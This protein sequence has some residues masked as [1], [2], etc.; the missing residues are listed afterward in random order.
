MKETEKYTLRIWI[1][2]FSE[3]SKGYL[4]PYISNN[5]HYVSL[6]SKNHIDIFVN[7]EKVGEVFK[8]DTKIEELLKGKNDKDFNLK[9]TSFYIFQHRSDKA[10]K[11]IKDILNKLLAESGLENDKYA[12]KVVS[13][14]NKDTSI[15]YGTMYEAVELYKEPQK[16]GKTLAYKLKESTDISQKDDLKS[17]SPAEPETTANWED[18]FTCIKDIEI[19]CEYNYYAFVKAL[20]NH[21]LILLNDSFS[22]FKKHLMVHSEKEFDHAVYNQ[23]KNCSK[24][25]ENPTLNIIFA[26]FD[27]T[28]N[29]F[30]KNLFKEIIL[31]KVIDIDDSDSVIPKEE[32]ENIPLLLI[33]KRMDDTQNFYRSSIWTRSVALDDFKNG[34]KYQIKDRINEATEYLTSKETRGFEFTNEKDSLAT[35]SLYSLS[36]AKEFFEFQTRLQ[37]NAYLTGSHNDI[38]PIILHNE[39][40]FKSEFEKKAEEIKTILNK[41]GFGDGNK[42]KFKALLIDDFADKSLRKNKEKASTINKYQILKSLSEGFKTINFKIEKHCS[43]FDLDDVKC[44]IN[45]H[46]PDII[47]LDYSFGQG[48]KKGSEIFKDLAYLIEKDN[49]K[50]REDRELRHRGPFDKLWVFPITAF[51]N[52]FIDEIRTKGLGFIDERYNLSRGADFINTPYLFKYYFAKMV[53]EI[54]QKATETKAKIDEIINDIEKV[55]KWEDL[56]NKQEKASKLFSEHFIKRKNVTF[57]LEAKCYEGI[58]YSIKGNEKTQNNFKQQLNFYEQLLYNLAYRNFEGNEE[59]IIFYDLLKKSPEKI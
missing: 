5:G 59:I 52:A 48:N 22:L 39:D 20:K 19:K 57:L 9:L 40:Y 14:G 17:L 38:L 29:E 53:L 50:N 21:Q 10:A 1:Y 7:E 26:P 37:K 36:V 47:L 49:T 27:L 30:S 42:A 13:N 45:T 6:L 54:I 2:P 23:L 12:L 15:N 28:Q 56:K 58:L 31:E 4:I 33:C 16:E 55:K 44:T 11:E 51:S 41:A 8:N 24:K 3:E 46:K 18:F 34:L 43:N 32:K 35:E 25:N